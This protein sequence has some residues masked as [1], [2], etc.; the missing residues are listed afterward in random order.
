MFLDLLFGL[1][2]VLAGP[3]VPACAVA[4][5]AQFALIVVGVAVAA[6]LVVSVAELPLTVYWV[7]IYHSVAQHRH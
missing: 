5:F 6:S 7:S 4:A 2:F 3:F 1:V